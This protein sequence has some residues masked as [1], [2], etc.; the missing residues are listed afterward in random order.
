MTGTQKKQDSVHVTRIDMN[1]AI[2]DGFAHHIGLLQQEPRDLSTADLDSLEGFLIDMAG[3]I[4]TLVTV[5]AELIPYTE[6]SNEGLRTA[7]FAI[8]HIN[9]DWGMMEDEL[10]KEIPMSEEVKELIERL[11]LLATAI[12]DMEDALDMKAAGLSF[13]EAKDLRRRGLL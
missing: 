12:N 6:L 5:I 4:E 11:A 2:A 7:M 10:G 1:P 3:N 13:D 9:N 8:Q